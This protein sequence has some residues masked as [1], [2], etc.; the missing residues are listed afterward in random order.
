MMRASSVDTITRLFLA[1]AAGYVLGSIV[2]PL[3]RY[4]I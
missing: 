3:M 4:A 2:I 1:F